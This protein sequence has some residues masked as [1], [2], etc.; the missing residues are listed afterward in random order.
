MIY[1]VSALAGLTSLL[2]AVWA[3][4]DGK[5]PYVWGALFGLTALSFGALLLAGL[6][7]DGGQL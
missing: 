7:G 4:A 2:W 3:Y 5:P 6:D 1:L